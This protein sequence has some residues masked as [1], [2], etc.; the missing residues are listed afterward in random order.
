[1]LD[2]AAH[3]YDTY[4]CAD[5][6]FISIGSIEPQFYALL[7][8]HTGADASEFADQHNQAR[9]PEYKEKLAAIFRS[10]TQAE[11]CAIME[12]TDVCFAPVLNFMDAPRHPANV[13]RETYIEVEGLTQP[14]PAP[15]FSRTPSEVRHGGRESGADTLGVLAS[16]GFS[17]G[18]IRD[19]REAGAIA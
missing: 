18:E 9:W 8:Q 17:D 4:E 6:E 14:A 3:F 12:G 5:G 19:L 2:G 16:M 15:R 11:W 10:K 1:M 7:L 13:A